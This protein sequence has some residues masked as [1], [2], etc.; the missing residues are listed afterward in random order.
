MVTDVKRFAQ[1]QN[2][3]RSAP[4]VGRPSSSCARPGSKDSW[5]KSLDRAT[6]G[7]IRD[8]S[9][10][11]VC[12][13]RVRATYL[14]RTAT[15]ERAA[16]RNVHPEVGFPRFLVTLWKSCCCAVAHMWKTGALPALYA[17]VRRRLARRRKHRAA[18]CK[19]RAVAANR[20]E[21]LQRLIEPWVLQRIQRGG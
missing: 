14:P 5:S 3:P 20:R 2:A 12:L 4:A 21:L 6:T 15:A 13:A 9:V 7:D 17:Q 16:A 19:A 10:P 18:Q 11:V 1:S 8:R